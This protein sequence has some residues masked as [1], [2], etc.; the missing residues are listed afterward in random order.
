MLVLLFTF[1]I[2][3]IIY[4]NDC[5]NKHK[6]ELRGYEKL[7]IEVGTDHLTAKMRLNK[8]A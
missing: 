5:L 4:Q 8:D 6:D 3:L 1:F 7:L 2:V